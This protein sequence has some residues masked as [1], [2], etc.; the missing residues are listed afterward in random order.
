MNVPTFVR[1]QVAQQ[2]GRQG[3]R[4]NPWVDLRRTLLVTLAVALTACAVVAA[5][6]VVIGDYGSTAGRITL[7]CLAL[8]G[9]TLTALAATASQNRPWSAGLSAAG[10]VSSGLGMVF[11][12]VAIIIWDELDETIAKTLLSLIVF[13]G[14]FGFAGLI[15]NS[16]GRNRTLDTV[17]FAT[18]GL[19]C[20]VA[21]LLLASILFEGDLPSAT[22][23]LMGVLVIFATLGTIVTPILRRALPEG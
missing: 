3:E 2:F 21:F 17:V 9:F 6:T 1:S 7:T 20:G 8:A 23:R 13:A 10:A 19:A 22:Y 15:L 16:H 14:T 12:L 18:V 11:S 4:V 5:A